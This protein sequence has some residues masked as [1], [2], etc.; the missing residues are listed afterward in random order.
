M[1]KKEYY[2]LFEQIAFFIFLK[3]ICEVDFAIYVVDI[4]RHPA[5]LKI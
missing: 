2:I 1:H 4:F 3:I 5:C